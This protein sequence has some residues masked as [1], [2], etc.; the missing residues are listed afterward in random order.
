LEVTDIGGATRELPGLAEFCAEEKIVEGI[1]KTI[2][3]PTSQK[4]RAARTVRL[5][6]AKLLSKP[7]SSLP[8]NGDGASVGSE[9][10]LVTFRGLKSRRKTIGRGMGEPMKE[11]PKGSM[12]VR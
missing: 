4:K 12:K 7:K 5:P 1:A 9:G 8:G 11:L 2:A 6:R 3:I 10:I